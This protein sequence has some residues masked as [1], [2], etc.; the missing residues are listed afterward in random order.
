MKAR[1]ARVALW[2]TGALWL[3]LG[4]VAPARAAEESAGTRAA[5]FLVPIGSPT[6]LATGGA[7]VSGAFSSAG[8]QAAGLN[9]ASLARTGPLQAY[10]AHAL[11]GEAGAQDW[12]AVGGRVGASDTRW[13][14]AATFRD[15]G[16]IPGRD[17]HDQPIGDV[18]ANSVALGLQLARPIGGRFALGA[19]TRV[20]SQGIGDSRG[21]GL[22]FDAGAQ[23]NLGALRL[24]IA[25]RDFGGGM[26]WEGQ[27]WRM[28][29]SL[30][31]GA[32]V[33][34]AASG[35]SLAV[36][37]VMPADY[38]RSLRAGAEWNYRDRLALR[39]GWRAELGADRE[40]PLSGPAFGL[41]ARAALAWVDYAMVVYGDGS[42]T[43]RFALSLRGPARAPF[44]PQP[45]T[46]R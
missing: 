45:E 24:G 14:F 21:L 6:L 43:H 28:P 27:R 44:G 20:V 39:G 35:L 11:L 34:H 2:A 46:R 18:S 9:A 36:D 19:G 31:L 15:E 4:A 3:V 7:G 1:I 30:A 16:T 37:F 32:G 33:A 22:A 8:L 26:R 42:S 29:A 12:A 23:A 13:A 40:E 5:A 25:G 17:A 38:W 41:G 10:F